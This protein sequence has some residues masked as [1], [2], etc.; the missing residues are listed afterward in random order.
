MAKRRTVRNTS[1]RKTSS[2]TSRSTSRSTRSVNK[3]DTLSNDKKSNI[4][5]VF[6]EMLN[7]VKLYH[8]KTHS[9]AQHKATDELYEH[10]NEHI[11]KFVEVLMGKGTGKGTSQ[12]KGQGKGTIKYNSRI[13]MVNQRIQLMD[14]NLKTFKSKIYEYRAFLVDLTHI[15][16]SKQD[17]DLLS[18]RDEILADINQFLYLM[19]LD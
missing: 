2:S 3:S 19:T 12:G 6:I 15:L 14:Q 10:L 8:W 9:Y 13:H 7:L 4:V 11:D 18:I 16:N 17:T 5:R 1:I